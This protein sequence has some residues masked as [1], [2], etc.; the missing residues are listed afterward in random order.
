MKIINEEPCNYLT[1]AQ[2]WI[3]WFKCQDSFLGKGWCFVTFDINV[4]SH[5]C[6]IWLVWY[7]AKTKSPWNTDLGFLVKQDDK[8]YFMLESYSFRMHLASNFAYDFSHDQIWKIVTIFSCITVNVLEWW[9]VC[10]GCGH[11]K[12]ANLAP[13]TGLEEQ[14]EILGMSK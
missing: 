2:V 11:A 1:F 12:C 3:N 7:Q 14:D 13:G 4:I 5:P 8:M 10:R 9:R 6:G